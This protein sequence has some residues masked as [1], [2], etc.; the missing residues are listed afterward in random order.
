MTVRVTKPELN[1]REKLVE[2][3]SPTGNHGSEIMRSES[4]AESQ[5][6]LQ[7]KGRKNYFINGDCRIWQR[8]TS[9]PNVSNYGCDRFWK[10]N[11]ATSMDRDA[12]VPYLAYDGKGFAY[13]MKVTTN[14][15]GS[16]IGQPIELTDTGKTQFKE[17][18]KYTFSVWAKADSGSAY[19]SLVVYYRNTKFSGT[20]QV[21][22]LPDVD[23]TPGATDTHWRKYSFTF[24]APPVNANNTMLAI[25]L[26]FS[27][28]HYFTGFQFEEGSQATDFEHTNKGEELALC[29]R[30]FCRLQPATPF[31]NYGMGGAYSSTQAVAQVNFPVSMRAYPTFSYNGALNTYYDIVGGFTS[32]SAMTM[33]QAMGSS[34]TGYQHANIQV[35]GSGTAGNPFMLATLN[36]TNTYMDFNSEI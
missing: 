20:N 3:D 13:S 26:S 12:A 8:G 2:L 10:A 15:S 11:G 19:F 35:V 5:N 24:M 22:W 33:T 28:T 16:S 23:P 31:M 7:I 6:L 34:A 25:E 29:Q 32:F 4:V 14:G 1:L 9:N 21:T 36:N 17:G 18:K 27:A 30:Y